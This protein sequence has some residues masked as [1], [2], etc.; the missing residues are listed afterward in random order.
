MDKLMAAALFIVAFSALVY[1]AIKLINISLRTDLPYGKLMTR[2]ALRRLYDDYNNYDFLT[3]PVLYINI[4]THR[5]QTENTYNQIAQVHNYLENEVAKALNPRDFLGAC[6]IDSHN[7]VLVASRENKRLEEFAIEFATRDTKANLLRRSINLLDIHIGQYTPVN[8]NVSFDD[9]VD[10]ARRASLYARNID[11]RFAVGRYELLQNA[12]DTEEMKKNLEDFIDQNKFFT[13]IQPYVSAGDNRVV[14]A[15]ALTRLR[16]S[17]DMPVTMPSKFLSAVNSEHLYEKFDFYVFNKCCEWI[18]CRQDRFKELPPISCNF[19]RITLSAGN[20][21]DRFFETTAKFGVRP[22]NLIIEINEEVPETSVEVMSKNINTLY[23][24]GYPVY[25]DDF[26]IGSTSLT[27]LKKLNISVVKMDRSFVT[28]LIMKK[29]RVIFSSLVEL[30]HSLDMKVLVEGIETQEQKE[31]AESMG[32]DIIQG[33]YF[34]KPIS[35]EEYDLVLEKQ[36]EP[37]G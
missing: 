20:F 24:A 33:F 1:Y 17:P 9:A 25:L 36:I 3:T 5:L 37:A 6:S 27:D 32:V 18:S 30:A 16:I 12:F 13:I 35:V 29:N 26:G 15:E 22:E 28:D 8:S 2:T 34:F 7:F 21:V 11:A 23:E 31:F 19:S 10:K 4:F 14:G